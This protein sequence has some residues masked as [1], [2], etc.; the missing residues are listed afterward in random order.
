M[1]TWFNLKVRAISKLH[2]RGWDSPKGFELR[3]WIFHVWN[4]WDEFKWFNEQDVQGL[5]IFGF[6]FS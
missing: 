4:V 2:Y 6:E 3:Y 1:K 5:R